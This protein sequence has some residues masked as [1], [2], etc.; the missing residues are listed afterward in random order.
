MNS[1]IVLKLNTVRNEALTYI[2]ELIRESWKDENQAIG[3]PRCK[4]LSELVAEIEIYENTIE[5]CVYTVTR[6]GDRVGMVGFL[7]SPGDSEG[8]LIGPFLNPTINRAIWLPRVL[9]KFIS[10]LHNDHQ[11]VDAC[12]VET[13][14]L[15]CDT[16]VGMNWK[17]LNRQTEM[18]WELGTE[19]TTIHD[20]KFNFSELIIKENSAF[21][22]IAEVM[23]NGLGWESPKTRLVQYLD[24]AYKVHYVTDQTNKVMG[25]V[26]W[27]IVG[28][29]DFGRLEYLA[30]NPADR[31][32]G[33][34]AQLIHY[35]FQQTERAGIPR[36]Y[37]SLDSNNTNALRLY[38]K[39]GF[40]ETVR[41]VIFR[42]QLS[43]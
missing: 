23:G 22:Q 39:V 15:L 38:K 24:E 27:T 1:T 28:G 10:K 43:D 14:N 3:Y 11:H 33:I 37:L 4:D 7:H 9:T 35:V 36:L 25:A 13:N 5:H 32:N 19:A 16:L 42:K 18:K 26:I 20:D 34:G 12:V 30:V 41:S 2:D 8:Y 29:T 40:K 21:N 6:N 31:R 17:E